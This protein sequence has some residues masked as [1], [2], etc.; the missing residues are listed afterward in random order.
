MLTA[1]GHIAER[2]SRPWSVAALAAVALLALVALAAIVPVSA[3]ATVASGSLSQLE[4][5]F[6]CV[7]EEVEVSEG[8][9]CG[10]L[11]HEGTHDVFQ[12]QLSPDGRNA[13]SVAING[14]LIEYSRDL[15]NGALSVIGCVTAGSDECA[16]ENAIEHEEEID[17]P[18]AIAVSP[19]GRD[20]YVTSAAKRAVVE[21]E[22][23]TGSGVLSLM[24]GGKAC[25]TAEAVSGCEVTGAKGLNEPYGIVVSP[26]GANVYVTAVKGKA[27]AEFARGSGSSTPPGLLQPLAG[28][29]CVGGAGSG[30]PVEI[31]TAM[32]EPIGVVVSPDGSDVYVAAGA[33]SGEGGVFAFK[34]EGGGALAQLP[35]V[36]GCISEAIAGCTAAT[37]L[38]GAEDL[39]LS[40]DGK[41]VYA[42][43]AAK[44]ALVE[45]VRDPE[46]GALTQLAAPDECVSTETIAGCEQVSSV[47]LSRGVAISPRGEDVYVGSSSENG[48][49]EFSRTKEG[50]LAQLSGSAACVTSEATGCGTSNKL[51]GLAEA[52]RVAVSP[53]GTNLYVAGQKA[54]AI[55]ELAR[56]V[57]PTV[58][59]VNLVSSGTGGGETVR[60]KGIG[61]SNDLAGVKVKFGGVE[62]TTANVVSGTTI[63]ATSPAHAEG[64]VHVTVEDEAGPSTETFDDELTYTDKPTVIGVAPAIGGEAG[65]T[66]VTIVGERLA[67]VTGVRFGSAAATGIEAHPAEE[68]IT[69][70]VPPGK[71]AVDVIVETAHGNSEASI[72]TGFTYVNGTPVPAPNAGLFLQGYCEQ[73]GF[74]SVTL[75]REEVGGPGF[76]YENWACVTEAGGETP[77]ADAGFGPSMQEACELANVGHTVYAYPSDA[78]SAFSW[79]C[80][81]VEPPAK[82]PERESESGKFT[83]LATHLAS[84]LVSPLALAPVPP[85]KLGKTGNVAPVRGSVSVELPKSKVFVALSTLT[86][87]PLGATIEAT[88]G[89]VSVTAAEPGGKTETGQF[90]GGRFVL[91]QEK[92]GTVVAVLSG[93]N[94]SV[95]PTARERAHKAAA[96][97]IGGRAHE[98]ASGKHSVR[99]LWANAHGKFSTRGNYAAGAVQGT[100]WL[101]DDLCEGTLIKVTRDKVAVKNLVNHKHLVVK[102]GHH[103]LAKAP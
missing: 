71:G 86:Q 100:E 82:A 94:F 38:Q 67:E 20:V 48:G 91:T 35:S 37:A 27:V 64:L 25:V 58:T 31:S 5:P 80:D 63:R 98:A 62:A 29:E 12:V 18:S 33:G 2:T 56:T 40:P 75:Q 9:N 13:Y 68:S 6:R 21:L 96:A 47:G 22:R 89:T 51:L 46:T 50:A 77:I 55:V 11:V 92:N 59:S 81:A 7:G 24:N 70:T 101:T 44:N 85:P 83:P 19:D 65:G 41:N 43:S 52:R 84:E 79:G 39:A 57:T 87:V 30:C 60:I 95:C 76:A 23:N 73:L 34:R 97:G 10:T 78:N 69:V 74:K 72:A 26:D 66:K 99:K 90:F 49:A 93:G 32:N 3:R 61:F 88:H 102:Q 54:G 8:N 17:H 16:H 15:A 53:D 28:S 103:Y 42:T 4:E 36:E 14:D 1:T 45:L